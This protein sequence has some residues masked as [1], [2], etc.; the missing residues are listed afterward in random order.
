[1]QKLLL[2]L[3]TCETRSRGVSRQRSG[4]GAFLRYVSILPQK[5]WFV[6]EAIHEHADR[7][8]NIYDRYSKMISKIRIDSKMVL[9]ILTEVCILPHIP[10]IIDHLSSAAVA[11]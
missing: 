11:I 4:T 2:T 7:V 3:L 10:T 5:S 9:I 1:M 6:G 8:P